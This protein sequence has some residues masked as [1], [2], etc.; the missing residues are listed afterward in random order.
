MS[1]SSDDDTPI[2]CCPTIIILKSMPLKKKGEF[3]MKVK[4]K[5]RKIVSIIFSLCFIMSCLSEAHAQA[6]YSS[7][8][9]AEQKSEILKKYPPNLSEMQEIGFGVKTVAPNGELVEKRVRP[10]CHFRGDD[11][12]EYLIFYNNH[13]KQL[14][15]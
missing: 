10:D 7:K 9:E 5:A 6:A 3:L 8:T 12:K 2:Y 13:I 14:K 4:R 1:D 15:E 11:G